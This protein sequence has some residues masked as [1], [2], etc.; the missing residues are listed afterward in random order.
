[1]FNAEGAEDAEKRRMISWK[2]RQWKFEEIK[3]ITGVFEGIGSEI[4][5][6]GG[7]GEWKGVLA[8]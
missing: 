4:S 1:M 2:C 5:A 6:A 7:V 8:N 3:E